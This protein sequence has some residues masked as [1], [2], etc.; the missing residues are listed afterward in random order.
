MLFGGIIPLAYI[1]SP[2]SDLIIQHLQPKYNG[3]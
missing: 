1:R 2:Y 3:P